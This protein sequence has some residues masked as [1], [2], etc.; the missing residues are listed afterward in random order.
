MSARDE[1]LA[2][3]YAAEGK[4]SATETAREKQERRSRVPDDAGG[5]VV[6]QLRNFNVK[7]PVAIPLSDESRARAQAHNRSLPPLPPAS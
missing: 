7:D 4:K 5:S 1:R 6:D 3:R 2:K